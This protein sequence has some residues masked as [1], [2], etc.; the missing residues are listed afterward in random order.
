MAKKSTGTKVI[1]AGN[2]FAGLSGE[3][4]GGQSNYLQMKPGEMLAGFI[5]VKIEKDVKLTNTSDAIDIP[6][7]IHPETK[8]E[9]RM[10]ASKVFRIN[11]EKA[12]I[13]AGDEYAVARLPDTTKKTG[14]GKGNR[15]DVYSI[16]VTKRK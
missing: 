5:H 3:Q 13:K 16:L 6:V 7:A 11:V 9:I 2:P 12:G 10:P 14:K 1:P 15:M 8:E 4:F